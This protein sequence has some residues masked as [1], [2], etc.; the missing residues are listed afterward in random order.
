MALL[1]L[2]FMRR[3]FLAA[4][5]IAGIAP[6]LGVFLVLRRQS[7]MADTLSHVSLAG[8]ALGFVLNINPN[9]TTMMIVVLAAI[10]LE[11]LRTIYRTYSEISIAILMAGGLALALVL[12]NL[13]GGNSS[14]SVQSYLF[15]SIV[16]ITTEQL[17]FLGILFGIIVLLFFFF[18]RP[19]YVLTFDEDTAEVDGLPVRL[20]SMCFN[21]LT[22]IAIA[23][24]IPI[25]G[26]LLI[27]AIMVLPAAISMRLGKS[28]TAVIAM[29]VVVGLVGMT[30]GLVGSFYLS[31]PPGAMI[32]LVFIA[33]FLLVQLTRTFVIQWQRKKR[34]RKSF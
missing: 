24:M 3:A 17:Y 19:M 26:A 12:M 11:Y 29:S 27:S 14:L 16:T 34:Q 32:T 21:I 23:V 2:E 25:A 28:F 22:G 15:G 33:I 20:M 7:L 18:R 1:S 6:M 8:V 9:L 4:L 30:S 31:T 5:F 10:I 13:N